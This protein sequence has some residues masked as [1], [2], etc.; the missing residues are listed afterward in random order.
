MRIGVGLALAFTEKWIREKSRHEYQMVIKGVR[1]QKWRP[2]GR[3]EGRN[4]INIWRKSWSFIRLNDWMT[5]EIKSKRTWLL[6]PSDLMD[7]W[8]GPRGYTSSWLVARNE[9]C[10]WLCCNLVSRTMT[11][12]FQRK[13]P[14]GIGIGAQVENRAPTCLKNNTQRPSH[15]EHPADPKENAFSIFRKR[16]ESTENKNSE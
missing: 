14:V 1:I 9:C 8:Q 10:I 6:C 7:H 16:Q 5:K 3:R 12:T 11:G 15:A 13:W 4:K 2:P